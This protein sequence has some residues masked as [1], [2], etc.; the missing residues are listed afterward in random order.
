[1]PKSLERQA[2]ENGVK[3]N[4]ESEVKSIVKREE[5]YQIEGGRSSLPFNTVVINADY[6]YAL[7]RSLDLLATSFKSA[8]FCPSNIDPKRKGVY[9]AGA[10]TQPGRGPSQSSPH[11]E[12]SWTRFIL[13]GLIS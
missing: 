10:S 5:G 13:V 11:P 4:Y 12:S 7:E 6:P 3:S 8:L 9:Y 1:M 2:K